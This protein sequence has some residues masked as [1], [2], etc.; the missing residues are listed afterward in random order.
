[1]IK[2]SPLVS[3]FLPTYNQENFIADAIDSVLNQDYENLEIV[4]GDD[5]SQDKTWEIVKKYQHEYPDIFK[6]FRNEVNLGITGNCNEV[7]KRCTG[8]YIA[9]HAGDDVWLPGKINAQLRVFERKSKCIFCYHDIEVFDSNSNDTI[10]NWNTGA[11]AKRAI[12]GGTQKIASSLV[13]EGTAFL[14]G[15]SIMARRDIIPPWGYDSRIPIASDWLM[16]IET[17]ANTDGDVVFIDKVL[18][19]YRRHSSNITNNV[20]GSFEEQYITLAIVEA[21]YSKLRN[22]VK[23]ARGYFYYCNAVRAIV[24]DEYK[25]GRIMLLQ[26]VRQSVFSWKW[27]VWWLFSWFKQLASMF[28]R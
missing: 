11:G 6:T 19:R 14:A 8:K 9:F 22:A 7:L 16:W 13:I 2:S 27:I 28:Q 3:V 24:S 12:E 15:L 20:D 26:G 23:R 4:V 17:C 1:M 10:R 5:C 25:N 18:A 21:R